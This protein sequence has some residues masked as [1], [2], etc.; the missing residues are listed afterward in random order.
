M[1]AVVLETQLT[2]LRNTGAAGIW[3]QLRVPGAFLYT[4]L[5]RR[6]PRWQPYPSTSL[7]L[8]TTNA[9]NVQILLQPFKTLNIILQDQQK[10]LLREQ[11]NTS[12]KISVMLS[13]LSC[14]SS[15][16]LTSKTWEDRGIILSTRLTK[17]PWLC[18]LFN[19]VPYDPTLL[20]SS[21]ST[22]LVENFFIFKRCYCPDLQ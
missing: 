15:R 2:R 19:G 16:S 12:L 22:S 18:T 11:T 7:I 6:L 1:R 14:F 13:T 21:L 3:P 17:G 8:P 4:A 9:T 20:A 10:H 5:H